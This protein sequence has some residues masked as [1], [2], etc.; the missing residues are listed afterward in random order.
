MDLIDRLRELS[1]QIPKQQQYISTEEATK[2]A[3]V[4]P[5]IN[6]LGYNV[7]DP[8]EVTP[9]LVADVGT[10]KG[11]KVDYAVLKDSSPIILFEVKCCG[12]DLNNVHASQLYRYFSVTAARFGILTD[13][14]NYH[15]YSDLDAPNKMDAKPFFVFNML[16]FDEGTVDELKKF[17]K[18]AFDVDDIL[19]T[20][21]ELRYKREIKAIMAVEFNG[22]SEEFVRFF[23]SRVYSRRLT[24]TVLEDFT[25]ITKQAFR[26]FLNERIESRLKSALDS[27]AQEIVPEQSKPTEAN[28]KAEEEI[29]QDG[30]VTTSDEKDAY[31]IV[32]SILR[33]VVDVKRIA[34]R[35]VQTY[36]SVLLDDNNRKPICRFRFNNKTQKYLGIPTADKQEER[37]PIDD[38]DD[39]FKYADQL[40]TVVNLYL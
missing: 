38:L 3:L 9:E 37:I 30:V 32:K 7:F 21:N 20:A 28:E 8:T 15:F 23:A 27:E 17:T 31:M 16:D 35:D 33:E 13:G 36:C 11:E 25:E 10:K 24:Q 22:P 14:I 19:S 39:I 40:K 2:N 29:E 12:V 26:A 6:A 1:V 18:S 5:F 34:M 4:M